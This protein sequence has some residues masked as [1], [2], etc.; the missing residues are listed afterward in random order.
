VGSGREALSLLEKEAFDLLL[1]DL[2]M[3][4]MDGY[5]VAATIRERERESDYFASGRPLPIVAMTAHGL[6]DVRQRCH[7]V[8]MEGYVVKPIR[9]KELGS[10]IRRLAPE[11]PRSLAVAASDETKPAHSFDPAVALARVGGDQ[12]LLHEL[13]EVFITDCTGLTAEIQAAL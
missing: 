2:Q 8:G 4:E 7:E 10:E 1:L 13:L 11:R 6:E 5:E 12:K 9:D 3:P